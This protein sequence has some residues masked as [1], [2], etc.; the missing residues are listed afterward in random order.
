MDFFDSIPK[1]QDSPQ[2]VLGSGCIGNS[3]G[4]GNQNL[5]GMC[6]VPLT[7]FISS[8]YFRG[9]REKP[10]GVNV[11]PCCWKRGMVG[12]IIPF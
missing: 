8:F 5:V 6:K 3:Y 7:S 9:D 2:L 10:V 1:G 11:H 12:A 4:M